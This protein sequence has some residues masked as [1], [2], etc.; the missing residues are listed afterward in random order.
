MEY[1]LIIDTFGVLGTWTGVL[2]D[3]LAVLLLIYYQKRNG[4]NVK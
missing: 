2:L 1:S 3:L 4:K